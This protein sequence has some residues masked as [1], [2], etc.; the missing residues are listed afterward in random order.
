MFNVVNVMRGKTNKGK[1]VTNIWSAT[2]TQNIACFVL[3][4]VLSPW[5][6]E[7]DV[8]RGRCGEGAEAL[9]I[10]SDGKWGHRR[11]AGPV[12]GDRKEQGKSDKLPSFPAHCIAFG[13]TARAYA[14]DQLQPAIGS[15]GKETGWGWGTGSWPATDN[16]WVTPAQSALQPGR[17]SKVPGKRILTRFGKIW[18]EREGLREIWLIMWSR[19][20]YDNNGGKFVIYDTASTR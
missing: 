18:Q 2:L 1:Q 20:K 19:E 14:T 11:L 12:W 4:L 10:M 13:M 3:V 6:S 9:S 7:R 15:I 5:E 16:C 8:L 17:L